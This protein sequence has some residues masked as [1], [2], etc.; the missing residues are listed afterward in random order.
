[1]PFNI[2]ADYHHLQSEREQQHRHHLLVFHIL[3]YICVCFKE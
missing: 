1:M 2:Q 3:M